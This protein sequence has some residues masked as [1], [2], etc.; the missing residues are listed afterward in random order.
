MDIDIGL[1]KTARHAIATGLKTLLAD[2]YALYLKTHNYHWNVTG[3]LFKVVHDLTEEQY[4]ALAAAVDEIAERIRMLG[5]KAP[6]SFSSFAKLTNIDD[7]DETLDADAMIEDLVK[8]HEAV[9][10]T[11]RTILPTAEK[12]SDETTLALIDERLAA[13]EKQAWMLR[14]LLGNQ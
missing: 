7:A 3:P 13:H 10:K 9:I 5:V 6:G 4:M 8:S 11:A 14:S 1:D 12:A 2:S